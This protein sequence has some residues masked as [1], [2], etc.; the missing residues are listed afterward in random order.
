MPVTIDN[1]LSQQ[2]WVIELARNGVIVRPHQ[3]WWRDKDLPTPM[4]DV[5]VFE[6]MDGFISWASQWFPKAP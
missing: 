4:P 6:S 2:A 5:L 1:P 3:G